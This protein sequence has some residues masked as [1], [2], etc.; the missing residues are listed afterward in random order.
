M[1]R[2]SLPRHCR[3]PQNQPRR[4]Q[5]D[6]DEDDQYV[7]II[8]PPRPISAPTLSPGGGGSRA[9]A[10]DRGG[11]TGSQQTNAA[12]HLHHAPVTYAIARAASWAP[13]RLD[14]APRGHTRS[15]WHQPQSTSVLYC[16]Q[17]QGRGAV[18]EGS[19]QPRGMP[20][21]GPENPSLSR[22]PRRVQRR[23]ENPHH[24]VDKNPHHAGLD[25]DDW[26]DIHAEGPQHDRPDYPRDSS[27]QDWALA[28][29]AAVQ[30]RDSCV[31]ATASPPASQTSG[32]PSLISDSC[33]DIS[34]D[35]G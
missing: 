10:G 21:T 31:A 30:E 26:D 32:P 13:T 16:M 29:G 19:P 1:R 4:N 12:F 7:R 5:H 28:H 33:S 14:S 11:Q 20:G 23:W 24:V 8:D 15:A 22:Q 9:T 27:G 25:W 34:E 17:G 35:E 18:R 3:P 2:V 6:S